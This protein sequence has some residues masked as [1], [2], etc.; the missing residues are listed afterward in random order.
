MKGER[1]RRYQTLLNLFLILVMLAML[2][3]QDNS[4]AHA[5]H[6]RIYDAILNAYYGNGSHLNAANETNLTFEAPT[7]ST[8]RMSPVLR[9]SYG[10]LRRPSRQQILREYLERRDERLVR[11]V[12]QALG[13]E[14]CPPVPRVILGDLNIFT[15]PA[16]FNAFSFAP[17]SGRGPLLGNLSEWNLMKGLELGGSW[18][19]PDC[20]P[21]YTVALVIPY[22]NRLDN[23][24]T[25]LYNMHPFLQ[26]Q[27]L[28]YQIFVAEQVNDQ[29]FNKGILMNAAFREIVGNLRGHFDCIIFH[30]VD[31]LPTGKFM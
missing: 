13:L 23:L 3:F 9:L 20:R 12:G 10:V 14:Y 1:A 26:K 30:D 17:F 15:A 7:T 16:D 27:E 29:P 4:R 6:K 21:R 2:M 18:R 19:P 25:F 24:N 22:K 11:Q 5:N 8:N 31:L 28:S